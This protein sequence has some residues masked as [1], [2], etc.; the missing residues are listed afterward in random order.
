MQPLTNCNAILHTAI[1]C[2]SWLRILASVNLLLA[3]FFLMN[4]PI[5]LKELE[6][7]VT[8]CT[9]IVLYVV[10][11]SVNIISVAHD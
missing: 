7:E 1:P 5:L 2:I 6:V 3:I 8:T 4:E 9:N 11:H 10:I